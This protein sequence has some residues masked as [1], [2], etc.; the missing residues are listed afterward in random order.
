M[1]TLEQ[2]LH[3]QSRS[4]RDLYLMLDTDDQ[5]DERMALAKELGADQYRNLYVGTAANSM[6]PTGPV[7]FH[8]GT[9]K[10]PLIQALLA[11]PERHWG[12]LASATNFD[13]DALV[14]HWRDRLV[15]GE[16]PN[17]AV[18][19]F[20]DN[21]VLGRA[22][23]YLQLEQRAEYLGPIASVCYWHAEQW[24]VTDNPDPGEHPLPLEPAWQKTP[25]PEIVY[26][27]VQF[28]NTRRYLVREHTE[29]LATLAEQM[30][31][32]D[33]LWGQ[34]QLARLWGW[35]QPEQVHF[36]LTQS[37]H[38]P[39]YL[40]PRSWLPKPEEAPTAHFE[41][42]YQQALYWQGNVPL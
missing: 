32:D 15:V 20:H 1:S 41:R 11:T 25:T 7:L 36:L 10:H 13:L 17:Q 38:A 37:L 12:W 6:A 33:W 4:G 26:A 27:N 35:Q 16:R 29:A 40:P 28:D 34:V 3:E 8:I 23:T 22:L 19:R 14:T 2:W 9:V 39:G 24:T 21:R 30:N 42:V 5:L 18:Y 31:V